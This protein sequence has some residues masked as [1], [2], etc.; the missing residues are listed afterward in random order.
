[1][2]GRTMPHCKHTVAILNVNLDLLNPFNTSMY[3][4]THTCHVIFSRRTTPLI[5]PRPLSA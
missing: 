1:M 4:E 5:K 2:Y 3:E